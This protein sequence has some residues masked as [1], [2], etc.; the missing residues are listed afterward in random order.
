M[1]E[2]VASYVSLYRGSETTGM[3]KVYGGGE[4]SGCNRALTHYDAQVLCFVA[5]SK[6][7]NLAITVGGRDASLQSPCV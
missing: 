3:D 5:G 4:F 2:P 6:V 1:S 7:C